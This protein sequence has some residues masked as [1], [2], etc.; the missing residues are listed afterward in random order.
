MIKRNTSC[1]NKC[2][3]SLSLPLSLISCNS[4]H[5]DD[6]SAW[7]KRCLMDRHMG[8]W[9]AEHELAKN[10]NS[11]ATGVRPN[12]IKAE[13]NVVHT[14]LSLSH[15]Q[16]VKRCLCV[17]STYL[18]LAV[19]G[20]FQVGSSQITVQYSTDWPIIQVLLLLLLLLFLVA[21]DGRKS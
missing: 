8:G 19:V 4:P 7:T 5:D 17:M 11:T 14:Y 1:I 12:W 18:V 20:P 16:R 15:T 21:R 9:P 13:K 2:S 10:N 3:L 6:D